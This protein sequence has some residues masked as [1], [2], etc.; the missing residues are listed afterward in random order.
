[1]KTV[2]LSLVLSAFV[3]LTGL[4]QQYLER[5]FKGYVNPDE[6]V[7]MSSNLPFDQ[8]VDLLS[9]VSESMKGK[10]TVMTIIT[11]V[12]SP[13]VLGRVDH[14]QKAAQTRQ[15]SEELGIEIIN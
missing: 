15:M 5:Q 9:K 13:W 7:T 8:A 12:K 6:L 10:I 4:S 1:M 3:S 14:R 11:G 2:I